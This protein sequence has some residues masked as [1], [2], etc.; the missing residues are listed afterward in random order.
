MSPI[1]NAR[2]TTEPIT[3]PAIAPPDNPFLEVDGAA[4]AAGE[5][6]DDGDE[7]DDDGVAEGVGAV[8]GNVMKAVIVGSCTLAHLRSAPEL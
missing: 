4:V 1:T 8:V 3:I 5:L 7:D 2:N 6:D